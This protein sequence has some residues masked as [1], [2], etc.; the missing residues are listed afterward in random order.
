MT[1][2][3]YDKHWSTTGLGGLRILHL[4]QSSWETILCTDQRFGVTCDGHSVINCLTVRQRSRASQWEILTSFVIC[5]VSD[6]FR[7]SS[8]IA[9][10][11][12]FDQETSTQLPNKRSL[13]YRLVASV[14][15]AIQPK[16][17][18]SK[19]PDIIILRILSYVI[20]IYT[21]TSFQ[22]ASWSF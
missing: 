18:L 21:R 1:W 20:H 22:C 6:L 2:H 19:Y 10:D 7:K 9:T 16:F 5:L 17:R 12:Y 14:W 13:C 4:H 15:W 11:L 3:R 8:L